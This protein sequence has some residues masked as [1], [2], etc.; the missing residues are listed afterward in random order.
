MDIENNNSKIS[1][2]KWNPWFTSDELQI[3]YKELELWSTQK[4]IALKLNVPLYK[5]QQF[6]QK[7]NIPFHKRGL[8]S[9]SKHSLDVHFFDNIDTQEKA[10]WLGFLMA[11]GCTPTQCRI[12]LISKDLEAITKLRNSLKTTILITNNTYFDKRTLK[13]YKAFSLQIN[14]KYMVNKLNEY[15][16]NKEKS[17]NGKFPYIPELF[18]K[19]YIRGLFDGDGCICKILN[20]NWKVSLIGTKHIIE[21]IQNFFC[22]IGNF[23]RTKILLKCNN[24]KSKQFILY[25]SK[26]KD[27]KFF[28]DYIY[29]NSY[30]SI[31][32]NRKYHLYQQ[33]LLE[34]PLIINDRFKRRYAER[35]ERRTKIIR[36][37]GVIFNGQIE[38]AKSLD[39][40]Q[41]C[42]SIALNKHNRK[43]RGYSFARY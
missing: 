38:A 35:P 39:V 31:Q 37:D 33:F 7:N 18:F 28:L 36:S 27:I 34:Y 32:L 19:D 20:K 4:N 42:I 6:V 21:Y 26:L 8:R 30:E 43:V 10:Y 9:S 29:S 40:H 22:K 23:S 5:I 14:S 2:I 17:Y 25:I 11:D 13:T 41:S 16:I 15:S 1:S 3:I 12:T 24:I